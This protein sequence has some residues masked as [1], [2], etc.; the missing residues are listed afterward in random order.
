MKLIYMWQEDPPLI[1]RLLKKTST[2][3]EEHEY[4]IPTKFHQNPKSGYGEVK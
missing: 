2:L 3:V 1:H 4:S